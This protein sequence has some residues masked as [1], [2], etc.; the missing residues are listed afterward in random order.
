MTLEFFCTGVKYFKAKSDKTDNK[1]KPDD[2]NEWKEYYE[3]NAFYITKNFRD[4]VGGM[5]VNPDMTCFWSKEGILKDIKGIGNVY[6]EIFENIDN[7]K[8]GFLDDLVS[9]ST[10]NVRY[11]TFLKGISVYTSVDHEKVSIIEESGAIISPDYTIEICGTDKSGEL[12]I[13]KHDKT[14]FNDDVRFAW[15]TAGGPQG[16]GRQPY[17]RYTPKDESVARTFCLNPI[18]LFTNLLSPASLEN[19]ETTAGKYYAWQYSHIMV[20]PFFSLD[21]IN[22]FYSDLEK[23]YDGQEDEISDLWE[24]IKKVIQNIDTTGDKP[25]R[26]LATGD[27]PTGNPAAGDRPTGNLAA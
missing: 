25:T 3:Q 24:K 16:S 26:N 6:S 7:G 14:Q 4:A 20:F 21:W 5:M 9:V 15:R 22:R 1:V 18:A 19:N 27:R 11:Q 12:F 10:K 13:S 2:S 17:Y 23:I 8:I